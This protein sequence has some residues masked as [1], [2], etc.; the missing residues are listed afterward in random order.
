[1]SR[2]V[3]A[4]APTR[5]DF[6]G[7]TLDIPPLYLFH[8]PACT[9]NVAIDLCAGA[10][11]RVRRDTTVVLRSVDQRRA[12]RWPDGGAIEWRHHPFLELAAR[13]LLS[14][15]PSPGLDVTTECQ[16]PPGAGTGGSSALAIALAAA[17]PA[18]CAAAWAAPPSSSTPRPWR[19]RP[20]RSPPGTRIT[21]PPPTAGPA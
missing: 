8:Q 12:A 1:V 17:W 13:L 6:A 4:A 9:V 14:F 21:W 18:C 20:S 3:I 15:A 11:V 10:T 19:R 16:A 7:G 2:T 5:I